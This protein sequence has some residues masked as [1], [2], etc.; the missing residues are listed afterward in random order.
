MI[1]NKQ[2]INPRSLGLDSLRGLGV[3]SSGLRIVKHQ[4]STQ[5]VPY[6]SYAEVNDYNGI[7]TE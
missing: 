1:L 3:G 6:L 2:F 4:D 7:T 5:L